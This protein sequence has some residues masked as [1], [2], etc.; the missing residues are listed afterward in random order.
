MKGKSKQKKGDVICLLQINI[1]FFRNVLHV[2][3]DVIITLRSCNL[4]IRGHDSGSENYK[5]ILLF[6]FDPILNELILKL[7]GEINY[8]SLTLQN[9]II[10]PIFLIG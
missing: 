5:S 3:F 7:K 2:I 9:K 10:N 4:S 6:N 1:T 8:F